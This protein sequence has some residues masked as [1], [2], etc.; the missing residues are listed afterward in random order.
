MTTIESELECVQNQLILLDVDVRNVQIDKEKDFVRLEQKLT[1]LN[2]VSFESNLNKYR[3]HLLSELKSRRDRDLKMIKQSSVS[4]KEATHEL[5][6]M[7]SALF[8]KNNINAGKKIEFLHLL[9]P[10]TY[11]DID[12]FDIKHPTYHIKFS[13]ILSANKIFLFILL[14]NYSYIMQIHDINKSSFKTMKQK[15]KK[16]I[17]S[18]D[19][20]SSQELLFSFFNKNVIEMW[21]F[22]LRRIKKVQL[23]LNEYLFYRKL[24]VTKQELVLDNRSYFRI[25]NT[26]LTDSF[27]LGQV[28]SASEPFFIENHLEL[29]SITKSCLVQ[30]S[31]LKHFFKFI[32]RSSGYVVTSI[33]LNNLNIIENEVN[34][35]TYSFSVDNVSNKLYVKQNQTNC[36]YCIDLESPSRQNNLQMIQS[37]FESGDFMIKILNDSIED[38][39]LIYKI[40]GLNR[41]VKIVHMF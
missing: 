38:V 30:Y 24:L 22:N 29:I 12:L 21:D 27:K 4:L 1:D 28:D 9:K 40:N 3:D 19:F 39:L 15:L 6:N 25:F 37:K 26:H 2:A 8:Y 7:D 34:F 14:E 5:Y 23:E 35:H 32:S 17:Y 13:S 33:D 18:Y 41:N 16:S 31:A 20:H 11:H 36:I 10:K